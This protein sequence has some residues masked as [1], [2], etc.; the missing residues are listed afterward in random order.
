MSMIEI[1]NQ[2]ISNLLGVLELVSLIIIIICVLT[3]VTFIFINFVEGSKRHKTKQKKKSIVET[4]TMFL[5]FFLYYFLIK[6]NVGLIQINNINLRVL[7][8]IVGLI[9][10]VIGTIVNVKG[11][12]RLGK[13]WANQIKIYEDHT[14]VTSGVYGVVRHP[15]YASLI[16]MFYGG[17]LVYLNWSAFLVTT[18]IFIPFMVYRAKQEEKLL[19]KQFNDYSRYKQKVGMFF[20]KIVK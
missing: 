5:F 13:N 18:I 20:P 6:F 10:I 19:S 1:I 16:W 4:G 7:T 2:K 14:L 11:R 9:L 8:I 17:S 3:I 12:I 15:L